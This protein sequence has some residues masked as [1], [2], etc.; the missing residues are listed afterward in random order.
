MGRF[1]AKGVT[2][3]CARL[4]RLAPCQHEDH[5]SCA[6]GVCIGAATVGYRRLPRVPLTPRRSHPAHLADA[7]TSFLFEM[8]AARAEEFAARLM[9][10]FSF[11]PMGV[12]SI[13]V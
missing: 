4:A 13:S 9:A 10:P 2:C 3:A 6:G 7:M 5:H 11:T 1:A 12:N 8:P